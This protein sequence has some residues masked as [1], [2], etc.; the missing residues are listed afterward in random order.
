MS[1]VRVKIRE[2]AVALLSELGEL[3]GELI[4]SRVIT[5][6]FHILVDFVFWSYCHGSVTEPDWGTYVFQMSREIC[7]TDLR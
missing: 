4:V 7:L 2:L 5:K 1:A 6:D 3:W